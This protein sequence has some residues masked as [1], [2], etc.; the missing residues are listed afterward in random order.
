MRRYMRRRSEIEG[1]RDILRR[2]CGRRR[3]VT[4][5]KSLELFVRLLLLICRLDT[6]LLL[7]S[8]HK[9]IPRWRSG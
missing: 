2:C 4:D 9:Q 1:S 7:L 3:R 8:I 6:R 5:E